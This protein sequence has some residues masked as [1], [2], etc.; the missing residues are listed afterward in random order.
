L[1]CESKD[2]QAKIEKLNTRLKNAKEVM[3]DG[4]MERS[5]YKEIKAE[6]EPEIE[7]LK[8]VQT[9]TNSLEDYYK[10]LR[11]ER[12]VDFKGLSDHLRCC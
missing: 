11:Q 1:I 5:E 3:L 12:A 7:K 2:T 10:L 9:A 8:K 6:L 4:E